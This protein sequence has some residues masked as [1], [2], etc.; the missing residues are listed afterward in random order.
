[1]GFLMHHHATAFVRFQ[2]VILCT[3]VYDTKKVLPFARKPFRH[4]MRSFL[5]IF[6]FSFAG[7]DFLGHV[8]NLFLVCMS[9]YV[10]CLYTAI[11]IRNY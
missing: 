9:I 4:E 3:K 7:G 10:Y 1:M 2:K 11:C 6:F 5:A 8:M